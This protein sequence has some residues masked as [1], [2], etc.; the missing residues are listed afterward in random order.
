MLQ[1]LTQDYYLTYESY[2]D[3]TCYAEYYMDYAMKLYIL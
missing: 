3:M 2:N 1:L